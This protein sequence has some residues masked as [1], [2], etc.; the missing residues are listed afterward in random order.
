VAL[1]QSLHRPSAG[2]IGPG[3]HAA[4]QLAAR[5]LLVVRPTGS[6]RAA[7]EVMMARKITEDC[8][9]CGACEA[10]CPH[11]AI[12]SGDEIYGIDATKCDECKN[13]E[14][15]GCVSVCPVAEDAIAMAA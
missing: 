8:I 3:R 2:A 14:E 1:A 13:E 12:S 7:M 6:P 11:E 4:Q 9:N 5:S 10:E 15:P